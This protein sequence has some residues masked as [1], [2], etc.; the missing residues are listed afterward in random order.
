MTLPT[1]EPLRPLLNAR[2]DRPASGCITYQGVAPAEPK[3]M[4]ED[5]RHYGPRAE[6][7]RRGDYGWEDK[8]TDQCCAGHV[9]GE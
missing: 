4:L 8:N 9:T 5:R 3:G 6:Q 7:K 1:G 2:N